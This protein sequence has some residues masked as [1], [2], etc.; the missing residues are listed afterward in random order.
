MTINRPACCEPN[1]RL[2]IDIYLAQPFL[3]SGFWLLSSN[4]IRV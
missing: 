4:L 2:I 1:A 3:A